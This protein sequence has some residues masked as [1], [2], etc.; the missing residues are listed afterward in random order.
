MVEQLL[1]Q[2]RG[3]QG[4]SRPGELGD[5]KVVRNSAAS[6]LRFMISLPIPFIILPLMVH[7]LGTVR[8]GIWALTSVL[9]QFAQLGD[10]GISFMLIKSVSEMKAVQDIARL[11]SILSTALVL[12]TMVAGA[13]GLLT[14][15]FTGILVHQ[16][17]YIPG[18]LIGDAK[19]VLTGVVCFFCVNLVFSIFTSV[20]NGLQRM[21]VSNGIAFASTI[22]NAIGVV[23]AL[24]MGLGLR[25]L[26]INN[27]FVTLCSGL[28]GWLAVRKVEPGIRLAPSMFCRRE[29]KGMLAYGTNIQI[30]SIA[31]LA[32]D[33]LV[34]TLIS[35][36]VGIESVAYYDIAVRLIYP[37]RSLFV[38]A[39]APLMPFT[40]E[41]AAMADKGTIVSL[42]KR[43]TRYIILSAVPLLA[44]IFISAT[45]FLRSWIGPGYEATAWTLRI[46]LIANLVSI[47]SLPIG[48][49]LTITHVRLMAI[50]GIANG[51]LLAVACVL[52]GRFWGYSGIIVGYGLTMTSLSILGFFVFWR[53][54]D[55]RPNSLY[56]HFPLESVLFSFG[57][58]AVYRVVLMRWLRPGIPGLA[59]M[60]FTFVGIYAAFLGISHPISNDELRQLT[61]A[62][63]RTGS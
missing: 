55:I 6:V 19:F 17:F 9:S 4:K 22:M 12:Y 5:A 23:V 35:R 43:S 44:L 27:G 24:S 48:N 45:A 13:I 11:G 29:L 56:P 58:A 3:G 63:R 37:I 8:Y 18:A 36:I 39:V 59:V 30:I 7:R 61:R 54:F 34:K 14:V 38:Q 62:L 52:L 53:V 20:L 32:G 28:A 16:V 10:F 1:L 15:A 57:L 50:F 2:G 41:L 26:V 60:G 21:D 40:A 33:P 51:L 31:N 47:I 49:I 42:Y 46:M 25:G